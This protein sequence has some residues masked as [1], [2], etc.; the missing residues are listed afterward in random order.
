[1]QRSKYPYTAHSSAKVIRHAVAINERRAKFRQDLITSGQLERQEDRLRGL[2]RY[3]TG[4]VSPR[5]QSSPEIIPGGQA[6]EIEAI[7]RL[8]LPVI[9]LPPGEEGEEDFQDTQA[10]HDT[11]AHSELATPV[12]TQST[13]DLA[14]SMVTRSTED[15][16]QPQRH[17]LNVPP[18]NAGIRRESMAEPMMTNSMEDIRNRA[19]S[20]SPK[21]VHTFHSNGSQ[22]HPVIP[23]KSERLRGYS[24]QRKPQDI[25][26]VWFPGCHADIGGGWAKADGEKWQLSHMPVSNSVPPKMCRCRRK[27]CCTLGSRQ[28]SQAKERR[29]FNLPKGWES[30]NL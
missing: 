26:E 24:T 19:A 5:E 13:E 21:H 28:K 8:P 4:L 10:T 12:L 18:I 11:D 2:H 23:H 16:Q 22:P 29:T 14:Q 20:Q 15:V 27:I 1:M 7:Q 17:D 6:N 3:G 25:E 9:N 30:G